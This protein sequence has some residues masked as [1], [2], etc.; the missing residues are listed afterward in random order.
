MPFIS[1]PS[2]NFTTNVRNVTSNEQ[3]YQPADDGWW[4][5][6]GWSVSESSWS[7]SPDSVV[8]NGSFE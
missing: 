7:K 5:N 8:D 6:A 2:L 3:P 4:Q 1:V